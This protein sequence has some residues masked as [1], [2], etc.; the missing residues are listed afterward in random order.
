[1]AQPPYQDPDYQYTSNDPYGQQPGAPHYPQQTSP[2]ASQPGYPEPTL[3]PAGPPTGGVHGGAKKRQYAAQAF[4][5]GSGANAA[6]TP[7]MSGGAYAA[8]MGPPGYPAETFTPAPVGYI[9]S[10]PSYE[11]SGV[12]GMA[13]QFG[14]M[15][16][17]GQPQPISPQLQV[18]PIPPTSNDL[19]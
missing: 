8:G 10:Q 17:G 16:F 3:P 2:Y 5:F 14:Q 13:N 12:A 18:Q 4:E 9:P 19:V 11:T 7:P 6:L 1:M 15:G